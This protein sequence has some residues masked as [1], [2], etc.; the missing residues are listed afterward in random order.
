MVQTARQLRQIGDG[1]E[2]WKIETGRSPAPEAKGLAVTGIR[3][4]GRIW[5]DSL[6]VRRR[7][8]RFITMLRAKLA[9]LIG[10]VGAA[11]AAGCVEPESHR[12]VFD[13]DRTYS[14]VDRSAELLEL[15]TDSIVQLE[16]NAIRRLMVIAKDGRYEDD[17]AAA[18]SPT[19]HAKIFAVDGDKEV[20][21][22]ISL[23]YSAR[24]ALDND[25]WR[26]SARRTYERRPAPNDSG[27]WTTSVDRADLTR[28]REPEGER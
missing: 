15:S 22:L 3:G 20:A 11:S 10:A 1:S 6:P 14:V 13:S 17:M 12:R 25:R 18:L 7:R 9:I 16:Q 27:L 2:R 19:A 4:A 26:S 28:E 24:M 5:P 23:V 21:E 8:R